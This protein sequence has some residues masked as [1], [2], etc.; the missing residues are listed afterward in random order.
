VIAIVYANVGRWVADCPQPFCRNAE[1]AGMYEGEFGGLTE[2]AMHCRRC[3][4]AWP[5]TWPPPYT[6]VAIEQ[7]LMERPDPLN[8]NWLPTQTVSE[9][10]AENMEHGILPA[11]ALAAA[12]DAPDGP[13]LRAFDVTPEEITV[14]RILLPTSRERLSLGGD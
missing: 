4:T 12:A 13:V 7:L 9:L 11:A 3:N 8:R 14:G 6:R 2:A 5:V 1:H 10:A